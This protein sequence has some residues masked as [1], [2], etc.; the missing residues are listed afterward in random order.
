[1]TAIVIFIVTLIISLYFHAKK[2]QMLPATTVF[3]IF[4]YLGFMIARYKEL[5]EIKNLIWI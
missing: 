3:A 1:M 2:K 4:I 5:Q